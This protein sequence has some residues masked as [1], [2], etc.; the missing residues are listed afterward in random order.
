MGAQVGILSL[1]QLQIHDHY[2]DNV[3]GPI[4][5]VTRADSANVRILSGPQRFSPAGVGAWAMMKRIQVL[6][7]SPGACTIN[8]TLTRA[9][10]AGTIHAQAR[11]CRGATLLLAG[12]D[13]STAAGPTVFTDAALAQDLLA[14]DLIEVWGYVSAGAATI[15][16]IEALEVCYDATI[17]S[18]AR[19]PVTVALALTGAGLGYTVIL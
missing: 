9:G 8:Y 11:L 18:I 1:A 3:G 14:G 5:T 17:T 19:W 16:V 12:A 2:N 10:G 13:N 4:L 6:Q 15:C 7:D